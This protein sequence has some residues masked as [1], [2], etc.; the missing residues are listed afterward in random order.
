MDARRH[1]GDRRREQLHPDAG[2]LGE[3][4]DD[5]VAEEPGRSRH[6]VA[7]A[8]EPTV[9]LLQ[10]LG[11]HADALVDDGDQVLGTEQPAH[12]LHLAVRRGEPEPVLDELGQQVGQGPD[13]GARHER[14][15]HPPQ[16]HPAV[17]LDLGDR[18]TH[19]VGDRRGRRPLPGARGSGEDEQA[20]GVAPHPGREV[21]ELEEVRQAGG[22]HLLP[23][24]VRDE[25]ELLADQVL[26]AASEV[27]QR[28]QR[29]P[30]LHRLLDREAVRRLLQVVEG[31]DDRTDLGAGPP[32][33]LHRCGFRR[34]RLD[35]PA[36]GVEGAQ[37]AHRG[38]QPFGR[39]RLGLR[40]QRGERPADR[41]CGE[42]G[43][44]HR[45]AHA[46]EHDGEEGAQ[47]Q[48]GLSL[49]VVRPQPDDGPDVLLQ[50]TDAVQHGRVPRPPRL[51][52]HH[53]VAAVRGPHRHLLEV[54]DHPGRA[55]VQHVAGGR[56]LLAV[57]LVEEA[58]PGGLLGGAHR[59]E[60]D[61]LALAEP[62]GRED[63]RQEGAFLGGGLGGVLERLEQGDVPPQCAVCDVGQAD[64]QA[65]EGVDALGVEVEGRLPGGGA[66]VGGRP[67]RTEPVQLLERRPDPRLDGARRSDEHTE[68]GPAGVDVPADP[69]QLLREAGVAAEHQ[70]RQAPLVLQLVDQGLDTEGDAHRPRGG[71]RLAVVPH[72]TGGHEHEQQDDRGHRQCQDPGHPTADRPA[73]PAGAFTVGRRTRRVARSSD[74]ARNVDC[75]HAFG[76]GSQTHRAVSSR[77]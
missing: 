19:D 25:P 64:V 30:A 31:R 45:A 17:V 29:C 36:A 56:R 65:G 51:R 75:N 38:R 43:E 11:Q 22:V 44:V 66:G 70:G 18:G 39:H 14:L 67:D 13:H 5:E 52:V 41:Q 63:A 21:V 34:D 76:R 53:D 55:A 71:L 54:R 40:G 57:R 62:A 24:Q 74:L 47:S 9:R 20:R 12:D 7:L 16:R 35:G 46:E 3:A 37:P 1:A 42:D 4:T 33:R 2:L 8:P 48:G 28:L 73:A 23:F 77:P 26:V 60:L 15:V 49:E 6:E 10:V 59:G 68:R 58:V 32:G 69:G 50:L 27:R 61:E 72:R